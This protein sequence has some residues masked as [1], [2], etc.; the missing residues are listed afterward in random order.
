[1]L[2]FHHIG[3]ETEDLD[4]SIRWYQDFFGCHPSWS[5]G[6]FSDLTRRR[7][8]GIVRLTELVMGDV[9][10]HL[11][12]RPGRGAT[13]PGDSRNQFQHVCLAAESGDELLFWRG[14][15]LDLFASGRYAFAFDDPPT[16]IVI[17]AGGTQSFYA[18]D[19][20]GLEFE[21]TYV[22]RSSP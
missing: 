13:A 20:N 14:R 22:P 17:D 11:I 18:L 2:L 19:V 9:R 3:V 12:E 21:F 6:T 7:L 8:P 16:E 1:V 5:L 10:I 15:W 4:N